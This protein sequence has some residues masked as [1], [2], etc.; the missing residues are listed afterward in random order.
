MRETIEFR[1]QGVP[2]RLEK[3][4]EDWLVF[5]GSF[6]NVPLTWM[7]G[8]LGEKLRALVDQAEG[9]P[10]RIS[11]GCCAGPEE[12]RCTCHM[13]QDRPRGRPARVCS[14]HAGGAQ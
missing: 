10:R 12:D 6:G 9:K 2:G 5:F 8:P 4:S 13:H 11:C 1:H 7:R 3:G 14:S